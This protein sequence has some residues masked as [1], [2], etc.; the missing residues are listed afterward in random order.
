MDLCFSKYAWFFRLLVFVLP[1]LLPFFLASADA[2]TQFTTNQRS[3]SIFLKQKNVLR[4]GIYNKSFNLY[5][6][7][8]WLM[9]GSQAAE[10]R[11]DPAP[12]LP[13]MYK[14]NK[15]AQFSF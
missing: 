5:V 2:A 8:C 11:Q 12:D 14:L 6:R 9:Q 13:S 15:R 10:V 3:C 1:L 7:A 4:D